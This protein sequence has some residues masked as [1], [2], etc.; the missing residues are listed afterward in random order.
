M[1]S[2]FHIVPRDRRDVLGEGAYWSS[3]ENALYWVDVLGHRVNRLSSNGAVESWQLP[4][5]VGWV[6]EREA[7]GLMAGVGNS[8]GTLSLD[9]LVFTP[10]VT[11]ASDR[12]NHRVNDGKADAQ[13]RIWAGIIPI[14]CDTPT[15]SFYRLDT[16][17]TVKCVDHPYTI[18][19][20]PAISPDGSTLFHADTALGTIFRFDVHDDGRVGPREPFVVFE[21]EWGLPDGMTLDAEGGLWSACWGGN[22]VR[23]FAPDGKLDRTISL[24]A[25]QISSCVFAGANFDRMFV[26]SAAVDVDEPDAGALFEIDPGISGLAAQLFRG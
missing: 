21:P 25:S 3:R 1:S 5:Y 15:G 8:F 16:D 20:G 14:T 18:A 6:I 7:G 4:D 9:P 11:P 19:N 10:I 23:R 24:P 12:E 26:T 13:G 17:C 22:A 2:D